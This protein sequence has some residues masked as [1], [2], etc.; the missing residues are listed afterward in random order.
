MNVD[1]IDETKFVASYVAVTGAT[2][3]QAR[4][5]YMFLD[6]IVGRREFGEASPAGAAVNP[7]Q[8]ALYAG[9]H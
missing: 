4:C 1:N 5:V 2:E 6:L 3:G 7:T 8:K 9:N